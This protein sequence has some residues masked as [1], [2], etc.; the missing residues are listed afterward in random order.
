MTRRHYDISKTYTFAV[1]VSMLA[2]KPCSRSLKLKEHELISSMSDLDTLIFPSFQIVCM[3]FFEPSQYSARNHVTRILSHVLIPPPCL[4]CSPLDLGETK[5]L[6]NARKSKEN[7]RLSRISW[8]RCG[9]SSLSINFM[10]FKH[11]F[12]EVTAPFFLRA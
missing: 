5:S 10:G 11:E 6:L 8:L 4:C 1:Q 2:L 9:S 7:A 12:V 3:I